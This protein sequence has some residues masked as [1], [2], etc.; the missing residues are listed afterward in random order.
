MGEELWPGG[1]GDH[2]GVVG[3]EGEGGEGYGEAAAGG[4]GLEAAA[5]LGVGGYSAGDED[6]AGSVGL[7]GG[8]GL[9][10]EIAYYGVLEGGYEVEGLGVEEGEGFGDSLLVGFEGWVVG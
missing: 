2:G 8:E 7:G 10:E 1:G 4:F 9:T 5:E 6:A 3:G